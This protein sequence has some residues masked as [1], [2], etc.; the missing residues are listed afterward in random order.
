MSPRTLQRRLAAEGLVYQDMLAAARRETAERL[1][2]DSA[3]SAA[4]VGCLLGYS[5]PAAFHRAF[6]RWHGVHAS[7]SI[8]EKLRAH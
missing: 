1:L 6:K 7:A 3:L 8:D 2:G 4:E 5:E